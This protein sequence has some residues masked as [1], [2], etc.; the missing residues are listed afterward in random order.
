MR[1]PALALF[2][3]L[4]ASTVAAQLEEEPDFGRPGWYVGGGFV[5]GFENFNLDNLKTFVGSDGDASGSPG[6]DVRGGYRLNRWIAFEGN[7]DYYANFDIDVD[8][9]RVLD[10]DAFTFFASAKGYPLAGRVQPYGLFGIGVQAAATNFDN[11]YNLNDVESAATFA[12]RFGGGVD[13]YIT[14]K[15]LLN[16]DVGYVLTTSDLDFGGLRVGTDLIPLALTG[17][18]RF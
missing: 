7:L 14:P 3:I 18:Y 4:S 12:L 2:L 17:Q 11:G 15:F 9:I 13:V 10:A 16:L 5:Y 1:G 6:I 8:D